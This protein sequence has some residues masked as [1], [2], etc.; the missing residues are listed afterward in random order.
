[1]NNSS[2]SIDNS[3]APPLL[4]PSP[5]NSP[6]SHPPEYRGSVTHTPDS[7]NPPPL[8]VKQR[9]LKGV[10][11]NSYGPVHQPGTDGLNHNENSIYLTHVVKKEPIKHEPEPNSDSDPD[12]KYDRFISNYIDTDS[13]SSYYGFPILWCIKLNVQLLCFYNM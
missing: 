11:Q 3:P 13:D 10:P 2:R 5:H 4:L 8:P 1:M 7:D 6:S 9:K 12:E